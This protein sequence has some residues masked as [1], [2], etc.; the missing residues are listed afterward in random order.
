[1]GAD[2]GKPLQKY[3]EVEAV[4]YLPLEPSIEEKIPDIVQY[5]KKG[6]EALRKRGCTR[7]RADVVE[8]RD[9]WNCIQFRVLGEGDLGGRYV[10]PCVTKPVL[11]LDKYDYEQQIDAITKAIN[12]YKGGL[13]ATEK[14]T[15]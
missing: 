5:I 8:R 11:L 15:T 9:R 2:L 1:M 10:P 12:E 4:E 14:H 3:D 7:F 13:D 6:I